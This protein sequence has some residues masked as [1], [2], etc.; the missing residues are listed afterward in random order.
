MSRKTS[1][2]HALCLAFAIVALPAHFAFG[3]GALERLEQRLRSQLN[4]PTPPRAAEGE[5]PA[6]LPPL[7]SAPENDV[8][9]PVS[10]QRPSLGVSVIDVTPEL[11]NRYGLAV[12]RGALISNI[13]EGT[14]AAKYGLPLG[15]AIVSVDG[16]RIDSADDLVATIQ[17]YQAGDE[18]EIAYLEGDRMGRKKIRLGQSATPA[19]PNRSVPAVP[20]PNGTTP[21][22]NQPPMGSGQPGESRP[23]LRRLDGLLDRFVP[24]GSPLAN[25]SVVVPEP[26]E[27]PT[28][29]PPRAPAPLDEVTRLQQQIQTLEQQVEL[30]QQRVAELERR[31]PAPDPVLTAPAQESDAD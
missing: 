25:D 24:P 18:V 1:V 31:L 26:R 17:S 10:D 8:S 23:L 20:Q 28:L 12:R 30:L 21:Q 9:P 6:P 13:R 3:Q 4:P 22:M 5:L 19:L 29:P 14:A 11:Q 16:R 27:A 2:F 15:A 7:G